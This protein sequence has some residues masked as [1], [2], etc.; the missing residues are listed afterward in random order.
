MKYLIL[1]LSLIFAQPVFADTYTID[2]VFYAQ[3]AAGIEA[4]ISDAT[5]GDS[6]YMPAATYLLTDDIDNTKSGLTF[7]GDGPST[8]LS[9]VDNVNLTVVRTTVS[10]T[11]YRDFNISG[12]K[13]NQSAGSG[14]GFTNGCNNTLIQNITID[15]TF[16]YGIS[17][18]MSNNETIKNCTITNAGRDT[19]DPETYGMGIYLNDVDDI[20]IDGN[21]I[22][23]SFSSGIDVNG[24]CFNVIVSNNDISGVQSDYRSGIHAWNWLSGT[25]EDNYIHDFIETANGINGIFLR[26]ADGTDTKMAIDVDIKRNRIENVTG[27]GIEFQSGGSASNYL[28]VSGNIMTGSAVGSQNPAVYFA[29]GYINFT[30]NII[31]N[32][33]EEGLEFVNL[34]LVNNINVYHNTILNIGQRYRGYAFYFP[35]DNATDIN[36]KDNI[37]A[38][39]Q[40][41]RTMTNIIYHGGSTLSNITLDYNCYYP[42]FAGF[43]KYDGVDF[44]TLA[45]Y[46]LATSQDAHSIASDPLLSSRYRLKP[47]SPAINA[48]ASLGVA[49]DYLGNWRDLRPDIGAMEAGD[50]IHEATLHDAKLN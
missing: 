10:N 11:T 2:G 23:D 38:D 1:L 35:G 27:V 30:N 12:N 28:N 25:L 50:F 20:T 13:A 48:G 42:E 7:Y 47:G 36:I 22:S 44:D 21:T 15:N 18:S 6:I 14:L 33:H 17:F 37:V 19:L 34:T 5:A 8:V 45:A 46:Q 49:D 41:V 4:A 29:R 39:T 31:P 24:G 9:L 3:T 32:W 43:I 16:W 26:G 40:A